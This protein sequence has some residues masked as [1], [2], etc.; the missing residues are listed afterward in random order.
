MIPNLDEFLDTGTDL[1]NPQP[2]V[3]I[4]Q[5]LPNTQGFSAPQVP[6]QLDSFFSE[7][8]SLDAM[9][10]TEPADVHVQ[11]DGD[12]VLGW[13]H[14]NVS[15]NPTL[16]FNKNTWEGIG[17]AAKARWERVKLGAEA[18]GLSMLAGEIGDAAPDQYK[19]ELVQNRD[20]ELNKIYGDVRKNMEL[21]AQAT[22]QNLG[23]IQKGVRGAVLGVPD[24]AATL[25]LTALT[26]SPI[27][28]VMMQSAAGGMESKA[29]AGAAGLSDSAGNAKA[30][31]DALI[32]G[33]F[34]FLPTKALGSLVDAAKTGSAD[35]IKQVMGTIGHQIVGDQ[36]ATAAQ[37]LNDYEF[38]LDKELENAESWEDAV[39][40]QAE[41]Q[42]VSAI[43]TGL[44]SGV[45]A[46]GIGAMRSKGGREPVEIPLKQGEETAPS[47]TP[48]QQEV[49]PEPKPF[50]G[51]VISQDLLNARLDADRAE[52]KFQS[53]VAKVNEN[54]LDGFL[55]EGNIPTMEGGRQADAQIDHIN[56]F[57]KGVWKPA[58]QAIAEQEKPSVYTGD[59]NDWMT[60][61][62]PARVKA[63]T[64]Y[65]DFQS[66]AKPI[67]ESWQQDLLPDTSVV[68]G[69]IDPN[70]PK[71]GT[72]RVAKGIGRILTNPMNFEGEFSD[73]L[74]YNLMAHEFGHLFADTEYQKL[75]PKAKL[76]LEHEYQAWKSTQTPETTMGEI[77]R[78][79]DTPIDVSSHPMN[80]RTLAESE[81]RSPEWTEYYLS[82]K[83][84]MAQQMARYQTYDQKA[85]KVAKPFF[86]RLVAKLQSF[87][88]EHGDEFAPTQTFQTWVDSLSAR[89]KAARLENSEGD[90]QAE[91][92]DKVS[93]ASIEKV[94]PAQFH[95]AE[96]LETQRAYDEWR[97]SYGDLAKKPSERISS[98]EGKLNSP[99]FKENLDGG[100]DNMSKFK[101]NFLTIMQ[102]AKNNP[103]IPG[104][105]AGTPEGGPG[106]I[107]VME[108]HGNFRRAETKLTDSFLRDWRKLGALQ[109]AK[110]GELA[111]TADEIS[112]EIGRKLTPGEL[113]R[114]AK[115]LGITADGMDVYNQ[116][117]ANFSRKLDQL[118]AAMVTRAERMGWS[119]ENAKAQ[120]LEDLK[121]RVEALKNSNYFPSTRFGDH[122]V[123]V[124][125]GKP[126]TFKGK[127][128]NQGDTLLR[129][130]YESKADADERAASLRKQNIGQGNFIGVD[131][132]AKT[133][134]KSLQGMP[135]I[136]LQELQNRLPV[137]QHQ[138]IRDAMAAAAPGR[139]FVKHMLKKQGVAGASKNFRRAYMSY[140]DSFDR[141]VG[142]LMTEDQLDSAIRAVSQSADSLVG[143]G[144]DATNRRMVQEMMADTKNYLFNPGEE[145]KGW[146]ALAFNYYL[147]GVPKHAVL[148]MLQLPLVSFP[149]LSAKYGT[150]KTME[151]FTRGM[152]RLVQ[153]K[154]D[155]TKLPQA[156]QDAMQQGEKDGIFSH[157][158]MRELGTL[159]QA[160]NLDRLLPK[161]MGKGDKIAQG[162]QNFASVAGALFHYSEVFARWNTFHAAWELEHQKSGDSVK[163]YQA[164]KDA[165]QRS[166][167]VF[168]AENSPPI[169]RG[170]ARPLF[171]FQ[172]YTQHMLEFLLGSNNPG[173]WRAMAM[174]M[175]AAGASGLPFAQDA[176]EIT[177]WV[178]KKYNKMTGDYSTI[179]DVKQNIRKELVQM[180]NVAGEDQA[181]VI[182][183][184]ALDGAGKWGFGLPW[185][186]E[187][188]GIPTGSFDL[189]PS[190]SMGS[191][192]PGINA[193]NAKN[194]NQGLSDA[195][196]GIAGPALGVPL[197]MMQAMT[198]SQASGDW[199]LGK[200]LPNM[201]ENPAKAVKWAED[202]GIKDKYGRTVLDFDPENPSHRADAIWQAMG[203]QPTRLSV[204]RDARWA[205]QRTNEY[206]GTIR[207]ELISQMETAVRAHSDEAIADVTK[208]IMKYND[209][210]PAAG[211]KL[212]AAAIK[213]GIMA[214][215]KSDMLSGKGLP[216]RKFDI[217]ATKALRD[218]F[219]V[220]PAKQ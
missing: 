218:S 11:D 82:R 136:L 2:S 3:P 41:R 72:A 189:T 187:M 117:Q 107:K 7:P 102:N 101:K 177:N 79:R 183:D 131:K 143:Q 63:A 134:D 36:L 220:E 20:Q 19:A 139:G 30:S 106:F 21:E 109:I 38:G 124:V 5:A 49:A 62:D 17:E 111:T 144:K 130:H 154:L 161:V 138:A 186:G 87:H 173:K 160:H 133:A 64:E 175:M 34:S 54:P 199:R 47:E 27:P 88:K 171:V 142:R 200:F 119:D 78:T 211:Y 129:E 206:Y 112:R 152:G 153:G 178:I 166:H 128:Y 158:M 169:M 57:D 89:N 80:G 92:W 45:T 159:A 145:F 167:F 39:K 69:A 97:K 86:A 13:W 209:T 93:K 84:Y 214:R 126:G 217:P 55:D 81:S 75:G 146:G 125:A 147:T 52:Q 85:M 156:L 204:E 182:A 210:V 207:M 59:L 25:G 181:K 188:T 197:Q 26:R 53:T 163:A 60:G 172:T 96:M 9:L 91:A 32:N 51:P 179:P 113:A 118:H 135:P 168:T 105:L 15:D 195:T 65:A 67:L 162:W 4:P 95:M 208:A 50:Q 43:R 104:L 103:H 46:G 202:R 48:L 114:E 180:M 213:G 14:K 18:T 98:L 127:F 191:I 40:I 150:L 90:R 194:W 58:K 215:L 16:P 137:E 198:E 216:S 42:A 77:Q 29:T 148:A 24:M 140:M 73:S 157:T 70:S 68:L 123:K 155:L 192:I 1:T 10:D 196:S 193:I 31:I 151:A 66:R 132:L 22:P 115:F 99:E 94:S 76:A 121:G 100:T 35:V 110:V 12:G 74:G 33:A 170:K 185:I 201:I 174:L 165:V 23:L 61:N 190:L 120:H 28:A 164:A 116:M 83:E 219:P 205:A 71:L 44:L 122:V 141:H 6:D 37:S 184:L 203:M 149:H 176:E 8:Q 212:N 108:D 56:V